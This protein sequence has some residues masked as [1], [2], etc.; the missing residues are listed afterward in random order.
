MY[1]NGEILKTRSDNRC[2]IVIETTSRECDKTYTLTPLSKYWLIRNIQIIY[3]RRYG[4]CK[5][6]KGKG[7]RC[8]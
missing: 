1:K 3:I 2:Y 5:K 6:R 7:A 4:S 8:K